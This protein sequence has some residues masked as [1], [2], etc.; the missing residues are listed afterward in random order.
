MSEV[1]SKFS[2]SKI[3]PLFNHAAY[4]FPSDATIEIFIEFPPMKLLALESTSRGD[5][6][7]TP[8]LVLLATYALVS[9]DE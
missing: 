4:T 6:N 7:D 2:L 5:S 8:P 9:P 3:M 1:E